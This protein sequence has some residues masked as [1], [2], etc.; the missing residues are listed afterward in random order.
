MPLEPAARPAGYPVELESDVLLVDG[1]GA[2]IRPIVPADAASLRDELNARLSEESIYFRFFNPRRHMSEA[3]LAHFATVDYTS[4]LALVAHVDGEL[5]AV[6]RFERLA[7][8]AEAEVAFVVRDDQQGRGFGMVLLEHLASAARTR[9]ISRFSADTLAANAKMLKVFR[10]AGFD[11]SAAFES[12][13]VHV[14]L[15]LH[16]G[17]RYV[18]M[19]EE[20]DRVAAVASIARLLSPSSVAVIGAGR[21]AGG[22]GHEI[23]ANLLRGQY[24]GRLYA[25]HPSAKEVLG[26]TAHAEVGSIPEPVDLAVVAVPAAAVADVVRSCG[27]ARVGGLVVISAGFAE[28]GEAG[29]EAERQLVA[30]AR[31]HG[32]RLIG[33]NCLGVINTAPSVRMNA[34]FADVDPPVG[35]VA[36]SLQ[37]GGLGIAIL[38]EA[39]RRELGLSAFVS[40]GNKADVSGNDLLRYFEADANT[41]VVLLYLE[42]FGNP[43][44]FA[45]IARRVSRTK[46][47]VA[48]KSGRS[49][50]GARGASADTGAVASPDSAV[51]ALFRQAGVIRVDTLEEL[52]D[53]AE[54]LSGLPL[55]AGRGV[56]IVGN[57]AGPEVL[58]A[59]ACEGAGLAV[60][61]LSHATRRSLASI[62]PGRAA[63]TNP[64]D[65]LAA[66]TPE[67]FGR[68]IEAAL[69]DDAVHGVIAV[70]TP[71]SAERLDEVAAVVADLGARSTKPILANMLAG[72][73]ALRL[74]R[75]GA[76][77][78]PW[79]A[80]PEAA[81][82]ALARVAAYA[83]WKA[84]PEVPVP[85]FADVDRERAR[86]V[87]AD[88]LTGVDSC[89]MSAAATAEL[90]EAFGISSAAD[91][92]G[93]AEALAE[94]A[95]ECVIGVGEE[96]G[97]G[98]LVSFGLAGPPVELLGDRVLSLVPISRP[99]AVRLISSVQASPMLS[100][101]R[102]RP[103]ADIGALADLVCR[104]SQ[105]AEETP[106]IV[107]M[108][109]DPVL[110]GPGGAV[111]AGARARLAR[112]EHRPELRRRHLR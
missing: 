9:G 103:P 57:V 94:G 53:V 41:H 104:V 66:V 19:V 71:P 73:D 16:A 8:S 88:A 68:A 11:E 91:R 21:Q 47:I 70:Y 108:E 29:A 63:L 10:N 101:Y 45:S 79:F 75:Q 49:R 107:E 64:V 5:V 51:D 56:A 27:R 85:V 65:C 110:A 22:V 82:R 1:R 54:L 69:R 32:M 25:V 93:E 38:N 42:S 102:G 109:L 34:T 46:P 89:P 7:D 26:I 33:P 13:V 76:R 60:P 30:L 77:R 83:A 31:E 99:D 28:T 39:A 95:V 98:P 61:E 4:R 36:F 81:A 92:D 84:R 90:L 15:D 97:F 24:A 67:Q 105:L 6:A 87:V 3:E 78:V 37:S 12:G 23:L 74:L 18:E 106:E 86:R 17:E 14:T 50:S 52:F 58:A 44:H 80:Y 2:E 43:R 111:V 55:P 48:V 35:H 112:V 59:D 100:G 62:L 96:P 72:A 20:R 40:V